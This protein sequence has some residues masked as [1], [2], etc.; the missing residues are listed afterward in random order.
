MT[1]IKTIVTILILLLL[2]SAAAFAEG[3]DI[4]LSA[5]E[6]SLD[7]RTFHA[8]GKVCIVYDG[9]MLIADEIE[10]NIETGDIDATGKVVFRNEERELT[11]DSLKYNLNTNIGAFENAKADIDG[12]YIFG[13]EVTSDGSSY[14]MTGCTMT[15][16]DLEEPHY[17]F[18]AKKI[19]ITE[20]KKLIAYGVSLVF[21]GK[22]IIGLPR[23][24]KRL[25]DKKSFKFGFPDIGTVRIVGTY[26][27]YRIPLDI[28]E[29]SETELD[30]RWSTGKS[31]IGGLTYDQ[32]GN[33][34][35]FAK[36]THQLP[37]YHGSNPTV[38]LSR[39][40][41]VGIRFTNGP[42]SKGAYESRNNIDLLSTPINPIADETHHGKINTVAEISAGRFIEDPGDISSGRADAR[43]LAWASPVEID[44]NTLASAAVFGRHSTYDSGDNYS[45][46]GYS[47]SI[48][49]SISNNSYISL[50]YAERNI[51][52]STPFTFDEVDLSREVSTRVYFPAGTMRFGVLN[53]YDLYDNA[54]FDTEITVSNIYHCIEPSITWN[55]RSKALLFGV[56]LPLK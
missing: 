39:Q 2:V 41:E 36:F 17:Y 49:R 37:H 12:V 11:G 34:P 53:R 35:V 9:I 16:C 42:D 55:H 20:D 1:S 50:T 52:G 32:Q 30:I 38:V 21:H 40:P 7:A 26:V 4:V 51:S 5:D 28:D 25:G 48:S 33:T 19:V 6:Y 29:E 3:P 56:S 13:S 46:Y 24:K 8:N 44:S 15:T 47:L 43:F 45:V 10:G 27:G 54:T 31:F 14:K 18:S 23:I 22:R